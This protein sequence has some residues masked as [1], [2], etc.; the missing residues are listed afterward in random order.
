MYV[1]VIEFGPGIYGI[2]PA[3]RHY[4]GKSA[5]DLG[6][7][8]SAFFSSILPSPKAR[9]LQYCKGELTRWADA[10]I[11]RILK[12]ERDRGLL[13]DDELAAALKTPLAF[14][15]TEALPE[16]ECVRLTKLMIEKARPT[17]P[18]VV[19]PAEPDGARKSPEIRSVRKLAPPKPTISL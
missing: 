9:Y 15:R 16:A 1:N 5:K 6:P 19:R 8:E 13:T 17:T 14:D 12:L 18:G 10:K 3:A 2:G 7:T 11:Q 4:F